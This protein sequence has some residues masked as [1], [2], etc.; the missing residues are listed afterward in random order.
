[1]IQGCRGLCW[2]EMLGYS[3]VSGG[4]DGMFSPSRRILSTLALGVHGAQMDSQGGRSP[5]SRRSHA[6]SV[7]LR[8]SPASPGQAHG[9]QGPPIKMGPTR[10]EPSP[11]PSHKEHPHITGAQGRPGSPGVGEGSL[12][13]DLLSIHR[14]FLVPRQSWRPRAS[15]IMMK[16]GRH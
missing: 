4:K 3:G 9:P 16:E 13:P 11:W 7:S 2:E 15:R 1:M 8:I 6:A 10:P 12:F 5:A 14:G